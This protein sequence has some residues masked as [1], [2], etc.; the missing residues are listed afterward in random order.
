MPT[1]GRVMGAEVLKL[2]D[3]RYRYQTLQGAIEGEFVVSKNYV[4]NAERGRQ[5]EWAKRRL[6][7]L[8]KW[9]ACC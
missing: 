9:C 8:E 5:E 7:E 1:Q 6:A 4:S 3:G 2:A